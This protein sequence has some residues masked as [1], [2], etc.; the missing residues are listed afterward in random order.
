[1]PVRDA[2]VFEQLIPDARK[3]VYRDTGHL[4]MLE[5]PRRFNADVR[6]FLEQ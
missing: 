1:V 4:T 3:I 2:A 6:R 5:R